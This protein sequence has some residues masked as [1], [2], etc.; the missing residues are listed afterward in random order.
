MSFW[1]GVRVSTLYTEVRRSRPKAVGVSRI[2]LHTLTGEG[3]AVRKVVLVTLVL[4]FFVAGCGNTTLTNEQVQAMSDERA[5][6]MGS[7]QMRK[8]AADL[9]QQEALERYAKKL[10][11]RENDTLHVILWDDGYRCPEYLP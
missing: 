8:A 5:G 2:P 1:H 9:G 6:A 11:E 3:V 7:C 4:G 10:G